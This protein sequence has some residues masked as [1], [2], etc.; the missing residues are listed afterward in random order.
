[1]V[2]IIKKLDKIKESIKFHDDDYYY[3]IVRY[4]IRRYRKMADYTQAELAELIDTSTQYLCRIETG[5]PKKYFN[6]TLLGRIADALEVDIKD[7][8]EEPKKKMQ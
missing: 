7:F 5:N 3:D 4:N 1:M 6:I 8:F 2:N